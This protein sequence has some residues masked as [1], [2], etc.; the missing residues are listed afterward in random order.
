MINKKINIINIIKTN[1]ARN[2][3]WNAKNTIL[4]VVFIII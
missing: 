4:Q 3:L 2:I 1:M